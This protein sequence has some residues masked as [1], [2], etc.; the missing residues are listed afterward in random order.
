MKC[1]IEI[2]E[3]DFLIAKNQITWNQKTMKPNNLKPNNQ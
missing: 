3:P 2:I 1:K